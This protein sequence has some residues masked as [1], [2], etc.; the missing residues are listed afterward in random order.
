MI[1]DRVSKEI[2][3]KLKLDTATSFFRV[4]D[5]STV[6]QKKFDRVLYFLKE[7][8]NE[9]VVLGDLLKL[10]TKEGLVL[11]CNVPETN[12]RLSNGELK[13]NKELIPTFLN[14]NGINRF[15]FF[16]AK[17]EHQFDLLVEAK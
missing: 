14:Q 6:P 7:D 11:V 2:T 4:Q 5:W 3:H 15:W 9:E 16:S 1:T 10:C 13:Y 12:K 8:E 17:R